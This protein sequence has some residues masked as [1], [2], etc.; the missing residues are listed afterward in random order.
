M[1]RRE[2]RPRLVDAGAGGV[3]DAS[4]LWGVTHRIDRRIPRRIASAERNSVMRMSAPKRRQICR[5]GPSD[6]PAMG[7]RIRG[8]P[9][10]GKNGNRMRES[11][12]AGAEAATRGVPV[13]RPS[14]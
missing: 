2:R 4:E 8:T 1:A 6:T 13:A 5:N 3:L 9:E 11:Y 12:L 14:I 10:E 7:A